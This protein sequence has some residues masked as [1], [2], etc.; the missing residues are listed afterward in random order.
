MTKRSSKSI[1]LALL[2]LSTSLSQAS[3][4]RYGI[5]ADRAAAKMLK[6]SIPYTFG[7]HQ[8]WTN[9]IHGVIMTDE[10]DQVLKATFQVPIRSMSTGN[11]ERDCHM[12][13]SL[14]I[15]YTNSQFPAQHVCTK[16]HLLPT[17]GPNSIVYPDVFVEFLNM[18]LPKDPFTLGLPQLT[19]V[20]V[21]MKIHGVS[22]TIFLNKVMVTKVAHPN[23]SSG[24]NILTKMTLSLK[25]FGVQI[26]ALKLGPVS[27]TVKDT[28]TVDIDID[29]VK[30]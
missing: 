6:L 16:D 27:V 23:G 20:N 1:L 17:S 9:V 12:R 21:Q 30:D 19:D 26:K 25:D 3:E 8:G 10:S 14:G 15:D 7:V 2:I 4:I 13:E 5:A 11:S 28:V 22:K 24:F 29:V 18:T